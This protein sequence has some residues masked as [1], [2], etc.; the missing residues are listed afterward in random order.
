MGPTLRTWTRL[1]AAGAILAVLVWRLGTGPF[2]AGLDRVDARALTVAVLVTAVTT[3]CSAWRWRLVARGLGVDVPLRSAVAAYYRSQLLNTLLPGGVVGD[4]H[5]GVSHGRQVGDVGGGVR[6][7]GWERAAGQ[8]VQV[9]LTVVVLLILPSPVQAA[10]PVAAATL[11]VL[12]GTV[13]LWLRLH[14]RSGLVDGSGRSRVARTVRTVRSDLRHGLFAR[15]S[16]PGVAA[17]SA[18]VVVGHTAAFVV[19]AR[20]AG[21]TAPLPRLL[22]LAL[23]VLAAMSVPTSIGGWGPREGAAAAAF[24]AAGLGA[25]TGVVT[26]VVYGVMVTVSV[27]PGLLVVAAA[28][29]VRRPAVRLEPALAVGNP[30]G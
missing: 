13:A 24:A 25:A 28:A 20:T 8:V 7:V 16:W 11:V 15:R 30:G 3:V 5:R 10:S 6:S 4:V 17:A 21:V 23:L 14:P 19:A 2:L 9:A 29:H 12:A 18:V 27:L 26:A 22:P 1:A